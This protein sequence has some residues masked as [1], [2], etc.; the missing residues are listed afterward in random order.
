MLFIHSF[1][2]K[3]SI[4]KKKELKILETAL[5][6]LARFSNDADTQNTPELPSPL[7]PR[8]LTPG[9]KYFNMKA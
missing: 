8:L 7:N 5:H 1:Y 3:M 6:S 9:C 4:M 2:S